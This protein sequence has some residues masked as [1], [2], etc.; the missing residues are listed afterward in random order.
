MA[1]MADAVVSQH[2]RGLP[3]ARLRPFIHWYSGYRDVGVE[4]AVHRGLPSPYLTVIVTLDD[5]LDV[6][7]HPD[8][9]APPDRYDSLVGGL[10]TT[11]A[12][13][14]HN[15]RQSGIQLA[16]SPLG[17]RALLGLPAGELA[18]VDL[19]GV[20]VLGPCVGRLRERVRAASGWAGRFAVLDEFL[21][22]R[23]DANPA[24]L[25]RPEVVR[26]WR[27][28]LGTGGA[29]PIAALAREVGWSARRLSGQFATEIGLSPKAAARV[30]RFDAA[31]RALHNG[32]AEGRDLA[33]AELAAEAGYFDQAHL[34]RDFTGFAG[35]PPSRWLREEFRN[36]QAA[37]AGAVPDSPA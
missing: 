5:P 26:A 31:R 33:L 37:A 7:A 36:V 1:A 18:S 24:A 17:A 23:L 30:V 34:A 11:P 13:I 20:D 3:A 21:L 4:P 32:F 27:R 19:H 25:P 35:C 22:R 10:H 12:L 16:M 29:E 15:G 14:V 28:I 6:A 8:P 2:V 9:A